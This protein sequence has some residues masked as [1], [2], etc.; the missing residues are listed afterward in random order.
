[1]DSAR[2][3]SLRDRGTSITINGSGEIY[4]GEELVAKLSV[5]EFQDQNGLRKSGGGLFENKK[6]GNVVQAPQRTIVRQG[7]L[8]VSNVNPVEEMTNLIK[9]NRLFEHDMKAL[10][11]FGDLM[12][13]EAND[14]GKL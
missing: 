14:I 9:A 3:I 10:K 5:V 8:E 4:A 6:A 12:G 13:R 1:M 7:A 2:F 11:T